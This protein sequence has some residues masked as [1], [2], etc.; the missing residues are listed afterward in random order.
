MIDAK[1]CPFCGEDNVKVREG[2]T[3]RWRLVEC[4]CCGALGPEIRIQTTGSGTLEEWE[5]VGS[6]D[7]IKEWNERKP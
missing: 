7:A 6:E 2:S 4:Q 3:F 5:A 1:P